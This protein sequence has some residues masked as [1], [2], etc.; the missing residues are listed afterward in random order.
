MKKYFLFIRKYKINTTQIKGQK[1]SFHTCKLL[2]L[3]LLLLLLPLLFWP[4]FKVDFYDLDKMGLKATCRQWMLKARG[5]GDMHEWI[6]LKRQK[7]K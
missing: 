7:L 1:K 2:L 5:Y 3:L 6:I 4:N